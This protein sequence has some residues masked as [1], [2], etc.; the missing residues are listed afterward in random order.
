M[1]ALVPSV[2][3]IRVLLQFIEVLHWRS[4]RQI[5]YN[6]AWYTLSYISSSYVWGGWCIWVVQQKE[7]HI[8]YCKQNKTVQVL[9]C[10]FSIQLS[11]FSLL[12]IFPKGVSENTEKESWKSLILQFL[13]D[14]TLH[15]VRYIVQPSPFFIRR[16]VWYCI[17]GNIKVCLMFSNLPNGFQIVKIKT[18]S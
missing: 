12:Y 13:E 5:I 4:Q 8:L 17:T 14:T 10:F 15:G 1:K 11:R 18:F 2:I 3:V 9:F 6:D 16:L 7:T